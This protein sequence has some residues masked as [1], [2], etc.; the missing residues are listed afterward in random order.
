MV[1]AY[2]TKMG[3]GYYYNSKTKNSSFVNKYN[4]NSSGDYF[5]LKGKPF[6]S[7]S[8]RFI[9]RDY[10]VPGPGKYTEDEVKKK[11]MKKMYDKLMEKEGIMKSKSYIFN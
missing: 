2:Q 9:V 4:S 10:G 8:K 6:G 5:K 1:L 7:N 11:E 3:P